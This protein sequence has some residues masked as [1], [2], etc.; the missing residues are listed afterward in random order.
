MMQRQDKAAKGK[1]KRMQTAYAGILEPQLQLRSR[2]SATAGFQFSNTDEK[3]QSS[4]I[5]STDPL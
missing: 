1:L 4:I 3:Y 2:V 5:Q